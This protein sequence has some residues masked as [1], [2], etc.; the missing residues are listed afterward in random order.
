[1]AVSVRQ[2]EGIKTTFSL[3]TTVGLTESMIIT[4]RDRYSDSYGHS[5]IRLTPSFCR[6]TITS[7][8]FSARLTAVITSSSCLTV[9]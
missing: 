7:K 4:S 2:V 1:M 5:M 6:T 9:V 3:I 8:T